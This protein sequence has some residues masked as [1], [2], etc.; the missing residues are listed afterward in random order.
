MDRSFIWHT[1]STVRLRSGGMLAVG[2][3]VAVLATGGVAV[4][5]DTVSGSAAAAGTIRACYQPG[6]PT[7]ALR[8]VTRQHASCPTGTST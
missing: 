8:V 2:V 4:A 6:S 3:A 7:A 1:R 5:S